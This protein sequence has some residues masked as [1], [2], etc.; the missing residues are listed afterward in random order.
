MSTLFTWM[1]PNELVWNYWVNNYLMGQDPPVFDILAWNAD[2]TN[3]PAALHGQFLEIFEKNPLVTPGEMS[4][5]GV[6]IELGAVTVPTYVMGAVND[7]LT[8][9]E[10][11]YRTTQLLAGP[12]TFVLSSAGHIASQVNPPGNPKAS[13]MTGAHDFS[14]SAQTWLGGADKHAGSWWEHW[15]AWARQRSGADVAAPTELGSDVHPCLEAAPGTYA[16]SQTR[17]RE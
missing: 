4:A 11:T 12:S 16:R 1:R 13:Y 3:L 6:P 10:G 9:W 7:H 5:L 17:I 8:P 15:V 2:G 14:V